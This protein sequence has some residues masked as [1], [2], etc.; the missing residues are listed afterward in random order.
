MISLIIP[1]FNEAERL[2]NSLE[3]L[4][5]FLKNFNKE[6]EV[7]ISDDGSSD[8]T[9][10]IAESFITKVPNLKIISFPKNKGKGFAVNQ[11]FKTAK[12]EIVIFTDA[13]FSTPITE[14]DKL[15]E[16]IDSGFDIAIGSRAID[17]STVKKHQN[18][19]REFMGRAFN[20]L[21]QIIAVKGVADTQC[22][23]KAFRKS[24]CS[25]I[26]ENQTIWDFGFDV[27]LLYLAQKKGLK[28]CEVPIIWFNNPASRVNPFRDSI[29]TF[30]DLIKIRLVHY[31]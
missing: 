17:R 23:F 21:V 24:S 29:K 2:P 8:S 9:V 30:F 27:E 20:V 22:G 15:L 11:G 7:I 4:R 28:I 14:I 16:K 3:K 13:D 6:V 5:E 25:E 31:K 10:S 18:Y 1:T 12:G 26:F 19:F